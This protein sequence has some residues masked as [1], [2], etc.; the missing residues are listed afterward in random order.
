MLSAGRGR[1]AVAEAVFG[2]ARDGLEV[3]HAARAFAAATLGLGGPGELA[4]FDVGES[5]GA[6]AF[7]LIVKGP[8]TT[9]PAESMCFGVSFA[10]TR[11]AFAHFIR[12]TGF[13]YP[14][15]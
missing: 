12:T 7:F 8:S 6:T 2:P 5:A 15:D 4:H 13:D 10:E 3:A 9:A 1:L 11:C 14:S